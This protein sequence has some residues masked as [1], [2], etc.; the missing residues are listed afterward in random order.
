MKLASNVRG[1]RAIGAVATVTA[2]AA[3]V[4]L[5]VPALA[6]PAA[7][8]ARVL[9][10]GQVAGRAAVPW[11][12][13]GP[14]W[15]LAE[16]SATQE[17]EGVKFKAGSSTLYLV[18]PQGGRYKLIT[19]SA[20]SARAKW[21]LLGWSGDARRALFATAPGFVGGSGGREHVYQLQLRTGKVTGFTLP[22]N[23]TALGYTR[24]DGLNIL[25]GKGTPTSINSSITLQRY[26]LTGKLQKNLA[27]V[28]G[29]DDFANGSGIAYN[30]GGTEIAAGNTTGLELISNAGGVIRKLPVPGAKDGCSA[31]RWW[32]KSTVLA[33][34]AVINEP[35]PRMWLVPA[36]G[37]RPTALTPVRT[38]SN[39]TFD[40]GDFNAWQLSSGLY[41]DGFGGC[42]TLVIGRQPTHG[43]EQ[44]VKVRG[45]ASS[46]IVNATKSTLMVERINA[47]SPGISLVWFNP[48]T[49]KMTVAIAVRQHQAGVTSVVP[50]YIAGKF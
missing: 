15:A 29:I 23:V 16:Y 38:A 3:A 13:V 27:A 19:W 34:C 43:K 35:G 1:R 45:A 36:S 37:G 32:S 40:L 50:Y 21:Y 8:A 12:K 9:S 41:V 6:A 20:S 17:G 14:G 25:A 39:I 42:G 31:V 47:C 48:S 2:A 22:A 33:S 5:A 49:R 18:D 24:P 10:G 28:K 46:L 26:S 11:S 30:S 7:P 4:G 44:Q